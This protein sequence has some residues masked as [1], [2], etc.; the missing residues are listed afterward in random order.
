MQTEKG[1]DPLPTKQKRQARA[2][3]PFCT[4]CKVD[5]DIKGSGARR[6]QEVKGFLYSPMSPHVQAVFARHALYWNKGLFPR[7]EAP[8]AETNGRRR[9]TSLAEERLLAVCI[10]YHG[11]NFEVRPVPRLYF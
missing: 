11:R 2:L 1:I 7:I 3:R 10:M 9:Q 8:G 6:R 4:P 5:L